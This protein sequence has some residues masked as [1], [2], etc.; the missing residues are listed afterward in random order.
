MNESV[1]KEIEN[2]LRAI[3]NDINVILSGE[4]L[5]DEIIKT[6]FN[7]IRILVDY[8]EKLALEGESAIE[9]I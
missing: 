2:N 7:G 5:S 3:N 4:N 6:G 8:S 1:R 9:T